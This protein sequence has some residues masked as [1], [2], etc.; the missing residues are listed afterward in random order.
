MITKLFIPKLGMTMEKGTIAEW[1]YRDGDLVAKDTTVLVLDTEKVAS[2]IEAPAAGRLVIAAEVGAEL[3]CGAVIGF[4]AETDQEYEEARKEAKS[5]AASAPRPSDQPEG[6]GC[7]PPAEQTEKV[8]ETTA[9]I[10]ISPLARTFAEQN[11]V[12]IATVSGTGPGG[13][14]T[15]QDVEDALQAKLAAPRQEAPA[16]PAPLKPAASALQHEGKCIKQVMPLK[17]MRKAISDHLHHSHT[18]SAPVTAI[19]EIDMTEMIAFRNRC[20]RK[21]EAKG[22]RIT[23]T[24]IFIMIVG[25]ALQGSPMMNASLINDEIVVWEDVNVG[26]AV[27]VPLSDGQSGLV[28]P[29]IRNANKLSLS[30]I[31]AARAELTD[32]ARCGSLSMDELTGG[33]FT[34]TNTGTF[35]AYWHVQTPIINQPQSA[36][37]GTSSVVDRPVVVGG[38]IVVRPV[39]PVSLTFDHRVMDGAPPAQFM[40]QVHEMMADPELMLL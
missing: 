36:I 2:E 13:R 35:G 29:V 23:Y 19:S 7:Q 16:V 31:S 26:F 25:K 39:M 12:D 21:G 14:I 30:E 11:G 40:M 37:L 22:V 5:P 27:S 24:D 20:L 17:G 3:P 4:L 32:K 28:V 9:R 38:E 6:A 18:V 10:M 34:I 33:T 1:R 8:Q 15:K